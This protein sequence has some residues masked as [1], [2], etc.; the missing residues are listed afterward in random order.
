[1]E[2]KRK[3]VIAG[4]AF[5]CLC[6]GIGF[7]IFG[8]GHSGSQ[9]KV[10]VEQVNSLVGG[11]QGSVSYYS[12]KV[13]SQKTWD[14]K[15]DPSREIDSF[16]VNVGDNVEEGTAL[17]V[18]DTRDITAKINQASLDLEGIQM[19]IDN[20]EA[21]IAELEEVKAKLEKD[22]DKKE[23][24][25]QIQQLQRSL[26]EE[27]YAARQK[28]VEIANL[29]K[30]YEE[31]TVTSQMN[32][33]VKDISDG[34][35]D[36]Y[37]NEKPCVTI[38][39]VGDYRIQ[40]SIDEQSLYYSGLEVGQ[41]V[42]I[43]SRVNTMQTWD[44][45]IAEIDTENSIANDN[46][47]GGSGEQTT[48]YPFYVSLSTSDGLMLGQ[49]VYIEPDV[50]QGS[51][52]DGLWLNAGYVVTEED[53]YFVWADNGKGKLAKRYVEVGEMDENTFSY[54]I[55]SGLSQDDWIAWP[56][57]GFYEGIKTVTNMDEVD[58]SSP[59]Y[60]QDPPT[61]EIE[62]ELDDEMLPSEV[63]EP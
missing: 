33:V 24:T 18:Y 38:L 10:Y 29:N 32:G 42:V 15:R 44:G 56:M 55:L 54:E 43:R 26:M 48:K 16:L 9:D 25:L 22:S 35:Y 8:R 40:G 41:K 58:Y 53:K 13:E 14:V 36:D 27:N 51:Q 57:D 7:F 60:Q 47:Y 20:Y 59:L 19:A 62:S 2:K 63:V 46:Y 49:H 23:C 17:F 11:G 30:S 4:T 28:E 50:G 39:A 5:V 31:A 3:Y 1:M 21:Q 52:K 34:G 37:G 6:L 61:E 45:T 12:G